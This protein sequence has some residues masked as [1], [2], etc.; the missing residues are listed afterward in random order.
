MGVPHFLGAKYPVTPEDERAPR[1]QVIADLRSEK[2]RWQRSQA[3]GHG[4]GFRHS[5]VECIACALTSSWQ[6][7]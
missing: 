7:S 3:I 1:R 4:G 5:T 6:V 2:L